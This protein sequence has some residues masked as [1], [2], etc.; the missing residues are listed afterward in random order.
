MRASIAETVGMMLEK[1]GAREMEMREGDKDKRTSKR[2]EK[3]QDGME[4]T[5]A[6]YIDT[7]SQEIITRV[8]EKENLISCNEYSN[9]EIT[10]SHIAETR[11][12]GARG[13]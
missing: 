6:L 12:S 5:R 4:W 8:S 7:I 2:R 10:L 11:E 1:E 9:Q 3:W 13:N